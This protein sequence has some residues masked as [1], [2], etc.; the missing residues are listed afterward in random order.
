MGDFDDEERER[1]I[2]LQEKLLREAH[3]ELTNAG[4]PE[5]SECDCKIAKYLKVSENDG[6]GSQIMMMYLVLCKERINGVALWWRAERSGY[7]TNLTEA[8]QYTRADAESIYRIRGTDFP[9]P[10]TNALK[11]RRVVSVEDGDNFDAL[12]MYEHVTPSGGAES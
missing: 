1:I 8:G 2:A 6:E 11:V 7:T 12:R 10:V 9:V 4:H 5:L 3:R